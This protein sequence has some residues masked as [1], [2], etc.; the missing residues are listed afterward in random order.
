MH[1]Q[2]ILVASD[3]TSDANNQTICYRAQ[4]SSDSE[5][6]DGLPNVTLVAGMPAGAMIQ[7]GARSFVR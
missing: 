2:V 4:I 6:P 5:Q 7:T 3:V 1:G